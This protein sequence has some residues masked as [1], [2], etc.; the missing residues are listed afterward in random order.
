MANNWLQSIWW[1]VATVAP[2]SAACLITGQGEGRLPAKPTSEYYSLGGRRCCF[3]RAEW[4]VSCF[5]PRATPCIVRVS[6]EG[7]AGVGAGSLYRPVGF[8]FV[9]RVTVDHHRQLQC[10]VMAAFLGNR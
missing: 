3:S 8:G 7:K 4:R 5:Y 2:I 1:M 10:S 9:H 6:G